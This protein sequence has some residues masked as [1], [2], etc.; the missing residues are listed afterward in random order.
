MDA[1]LPHPDL[2]YRARVEPWVGVPSYPPAGAARRKAGVTTVY[3]SWNGDTRATSWRVLAS[4][5]GG[6]LGVVTTRPKSGF[7]TAIPVAR[8][9]TSFKV[10]ALDAR[11][12]VIGSSRAFRSR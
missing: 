7:E 3:A 12:R 1:V 9:Y 8:T 5:G 4:S 2:S 6:A 10:E 11:G